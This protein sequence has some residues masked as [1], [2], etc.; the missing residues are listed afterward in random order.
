MAT[1]TKRKIG[2]SV[3]IRRKGYPSQTR[4]LA[5]KA[6]A[7]ACLS[8]ETQGTDDCKPGSMTGWSSRLT[9]HETL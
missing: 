8:Y 5:S 6:E 4:T 7:Q 1:I 2:W 9:A 3:Q